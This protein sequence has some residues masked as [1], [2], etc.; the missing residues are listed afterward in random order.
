MSDPPAVSVRA[1]RM[2][3]NLD[4]SEVAAQRGPFAGQAG[5]LD[6]PYRATPMAAVERML[7]LA[8]VGPGT[9]LLDLGCGDGR[10]VLAAAKRGAQ[11]LG[12][13]IDPERIALARTEA[14]KAGLETAAR[15]EEGDLFTA[16]LADVDVVTLFLLPHVNRWLQGRLK[17]QL[18]PGA[19]V[20]G[21]AF[22]MP[23]WT[24]AAEERFGETMLYLWKR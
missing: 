4:D 15:F 9:R 22:P 8:E 21:Y 2:E 10:I 6:A 12:I 24:P 23:D 18:R 14:R 11:A 20:L 13:D 3:L 5:Q 17:S 7:D 16:D 19:R 1:R